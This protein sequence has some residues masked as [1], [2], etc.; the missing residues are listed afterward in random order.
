MKKI[1]IK[2]LAHK[3]GLTFSDL[4]EWGFIETISLLGTI[5]FRILRGL[6]LRIKGL[7][8]KGMVLAEKR[9][10]IYHIKHLTCGK[11]INLEEGCEIVALSKK[12][13]VFGDRCTIGRHASIR[14]TNVLLD[15]AGEGLTLGDRSN[16]GAYSYIGC[17]GFIEI[18]S[19]VMMGPRVNLMAENHNYEHT[20]ETMKAQGVT[21]SFIRIEDDCWLGA[22]CTVLAGV[23]I[24]KGS[25]I[26]AGAVVTKDVAP[27]SVV[28]GVPATLIKSRK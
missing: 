7:R 17:S 28:G 8:A 22:G 3:K 12:G 4:K 6:L 27:Y 14:T 21:R 26:A 9:V 2:H 5:L 23:T 24:G 18:G 20:D 11:S 1:I 16:I 15:E 13:I 10:Q 19:D 25:I